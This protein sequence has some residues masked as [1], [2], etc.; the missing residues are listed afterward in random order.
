MPRGPFSPDPQYALD[1]MHCVNFLFRDQ[2]GLSVPTTC[3]TGN[4]HNV[5]GFGLGLDYVYK[6]VKAHGWKIKVDENKDGGSIF[7]LFISIK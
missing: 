1:S 6:L 3:P 5:K 7:K 2:P 4:V